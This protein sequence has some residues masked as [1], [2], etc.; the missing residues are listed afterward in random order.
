MIFV[1]VRIFI[2]SKIQ[3]I[4]F[5]SGNIYATSI[6]NRK[7][8]FTGCRKSSLLISESKQ[9]IN[10]SSLDYSVVVH[11]MVQTMLPKTTFII[12]VSDNLPFLCEEKFNIET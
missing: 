2:F 8:S 3:K 1:Q 10:I 6:Y 7:Y 11:F 5:W 9:S 4:N 12:G